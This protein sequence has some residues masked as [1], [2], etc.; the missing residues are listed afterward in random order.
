MTK[1]VLNNILMKSKKSNVSWF[2]ICNDRKKVF[3]YCTIK[4]GGELYKHKHKIN[5][6]YYVVD[7]KGKLKLGNKDLSLKK[8]MFVKIP[9]MTYHNTKNP[10]HKNL[11]FFYLFNKGPLE[12]IKYIS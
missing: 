2:N 1:L 10:Y 9:K 8:N 11:S 3:G 7:G 5:E 4:P 12:N 6:Y